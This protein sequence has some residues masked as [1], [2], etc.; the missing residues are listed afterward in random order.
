MTTTSNNTR[1]FQSG[2]YYVTV[3]T[4]ADKEFPGGERR[5]FAVIHEGHEVIAAI[6]PMLS[7]AMRAAVALDKDLKE[8]LTDP[9]DTK[10]Q[11]EPTFQGFPRFS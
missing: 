6:G 9:S 11:E 10:R 7:G 5:M 4:M 1:L 8:A 2:P 3:V